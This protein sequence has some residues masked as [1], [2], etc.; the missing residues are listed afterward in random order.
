MH[1]FHEHLAGQVAAALASGVAVI[2]D[3]AA[4][5]RPF[6]V[7]L[8]PPAPTLDDPPDTCTV[9]VGGKTARLVEFGGSWYGVRRAVEP[10]FTGDAPPDPPVLLY[11]PTR[12]PAPEQD[13]LMEVTKAGRRLD[14]EFDREATD[15]LRGRKVADAVIDELLASGNTT[16]ED[17]V[18]FLAQRGRASKLKVIFRDAS[19]LDILARWVAD[20]GHDATI[21][22]KGAGTE[23]YRLVEGRL[24][25]QLPPEASLAK[26]RAQVTRYVLLNEFRHDLDAAA[27]ASLA[28]IPAPPD[29]VHLDGILGLTARLRAGFPD[30]YVSR[31]RQV[32]QEFHLAEA[33]I[34]AEQLGRIDTFEF[35]ERQL[36]R[37]CAELLEQGKYAEGLSVVEG[38]ETC[39]W[40]EREDEQHQM[41]RK[42]QW[43]LCRRVAQLGLRLAAVK[44]HLPPSGAGP[45]VW[46][47]DYAAADGC[48]RMDTAQR[49]LETWRSRIA[50]DPVCDRAVGLV[51]RAHEELA[52]DM[53]RRFTAALATAGWSV[54]E[55]LHQTRVH[56]DAVV[57]RG[58]PVAW[59]WVDALRFEM[60]AELARQLDGVE[61]LYLQPAVAALPTITPV[62][63]AALLPG[64]ARNFVVAEAKGKLT[65]TVDGAAAANAAERQ[66]VLQ[67]RV[68]DVADVTLSRVLQDRPSELKKRVAGRPL[69]VVRSTELDSLG[70]NEDD[71]LARQAMET[72]IGNLARAVRKLAAAG[73]AHFVI[74]ADHGHLFG[75]RKGDDMKLDAPG[76]EMIAAHRRCWVGRGGA[77]PAGT[78]R[79][80]A[81][82]LG[83]ASDLEFVFPAGL[84]VFKAGGDLSFHHG[85]PSLQE[86][87]IPV[88][89]FRV[90]GVAQK[91]APGGV[92]VTLHGVPERV[93]NRMFVV[94]VKVT[95]IGLFPA[96]EVALRV[97]L[98]AAQQQ[99]GHA[100]MASG[101]E[102]DR[103][104]GVVRVKPDGSVQ[105]GMTLVRDDVAAVQVAVLDPDSGAV[106]ATS[107]SLPIDLMR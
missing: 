104:R 77:T 83:Y 16:Y 91:A 65:V 12:L 105:L 9:A 95:G 37:W 97:V 79:V 98:L 60:G 20:D 19:D 47:R 100:G 107:L 87:V 41:P 40:V 3:A 63:M 45:E 78:V 99:V 66:K 70:E 52:H 103:E 10:L 36:L 30:A 49:A 4:R 84:G 51:L 76:G 68:P 46:V 90:P 56:P 54:P 43:E 6:F 101:G 35:E 26:A 62:G 44:A 5:F 21:A 67:A 17:V 23:L 58:G 85:G 53:A 13:V 102:F 32:E 11:V 38:R 92:E 82:E 7:E 33:A 57:T 71:Q 81:A 48:H 61:E 96:E 50:D 28:T 106:L 86:L 27:P 94:T 73:I 59:F 93:T 31:A 8:G 80:P 25:L 69:V 2:V 64:A 42:E 34:P 55:V 88:L 39:F 22:A 18:A 74:T 14:W 24:G 1:P 75:L 15:C 29:D 89:S 72:V